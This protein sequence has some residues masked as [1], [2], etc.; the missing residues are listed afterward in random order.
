MSIEKLKTQILE[1]SDSH[2]PDF[3]IINDF[4]PEGDYT[5]DDMK[6][7]LR[8]LQDDGLI[9]DAILTSVDRIVTITGNLEI[10]GKGHKLLK[11]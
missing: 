3:G 4:N 7:A 1:F 5:E 9:A 11:K 8:E 10:T 6:L 2:Y